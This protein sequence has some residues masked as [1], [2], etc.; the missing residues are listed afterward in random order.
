MTQKSV[1]PASQQFTILSIFL[2]NFLTMLSVLLAS[3][4]SGGLVGLLILFLNLFTYGRFVYIYS[5]ASVW[6]AIFP[7]LEILALIIAAQV[8]THVCWSLLLRIQM[9]Q[10]I[11][12]FSIAISILLLTIAAFIE[13]GILRV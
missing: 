8:G 4:F 13:G 3:L 12:I 10:R 2:N 1:H 6:T 9:Q 5:H 11:L 7:W